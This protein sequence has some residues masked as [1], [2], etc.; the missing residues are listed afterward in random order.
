MKPKN[1]III[2]ISEIVT[3]KINIEMKQMHVFSQY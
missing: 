3:I 2:R 1:T